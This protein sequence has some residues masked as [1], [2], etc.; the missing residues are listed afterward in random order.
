[1]TKNYSIWLMPNE[2]NDVLEDLDD[3]ISRL[4][5][6]Q[7]TPDF[8]P[9]ITLI[10]GINESLPTIRETVE[11][12]SKRISQLEVEFMNTHFSTTRH[13]CNYILIKPTK[14]LLELHEGLSEEFNIQKSMYVPHLS[15]IYSDMSISR[16]EKINN[17]IED[18]PKGFSSDR[19]LIYDTSG[20]EEDWNPV[21]EFKLGHDAY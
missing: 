6:E 14:E 1:M 15:L 11:E 3:T 4:S 20:K 18:I 12:I 5:K 17:S 10:G 9:H 16:R 21:D 19:L 13:Q 8:R 2:E 7:G